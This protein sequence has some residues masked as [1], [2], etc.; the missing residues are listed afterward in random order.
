VIKLTI[1][2]EAFKVGLLD[3]VWLNRTGRIFSGEGSRLMLAVP[4]LLSELRGEEIDRLHMGC[5]PLKLEE[6]DSLLVRSRPT[7]SVFY[8]QNGALRVW[9]NDDQGVPLTLNFVGPGET[10]GE[11]SAV[12]GWG[13]SANVTAVRRSQVVAFD[14]G[15]FVQCMRQMPLL[16]LNVA[17]LQMW[18]LCHNAE[19][20]L[21]LAGH[22]LSA[23]VARQLLLLAER[24]P[25]A[26][27]G[28]SVTIDLRLTHDDLASMAA[29]SRSK[30][31][32]AMR[33]LRE[34]GLIVEDT[35][36]HEVTVVDCEGLAN[37]CVGE[38][39]RD[40]LFRLLHGLR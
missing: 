6:G 23:R 30:I 37:L 18:R 34:L 36:K 25:S 26:T 13:C 22:P 14:A 1:C 38:R 3:A 9:L 39:G 8:I 2:V 10:V 4:S 40:P 28:T 7:V 27:A 24:F 12:T 17:H 19:T 33:G 21:S 16:S 11:I 5:R 20:G 35:K 31:N 32:A 15:H 29:A